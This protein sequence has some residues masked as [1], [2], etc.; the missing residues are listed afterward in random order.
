MR[1]ELMQVSLL[2]FKSN[3]LTARPS[4]LV[5][6]SYKILPNILLKILKQQYDIII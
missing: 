1:F 3:A 2:D 4:C 6:V 5:Y